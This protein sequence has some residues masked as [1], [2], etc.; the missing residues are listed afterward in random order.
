LR[1]TCK[2]PFQFQQFAVQGIVL[3]AVIVENF[4][5][6]QPEPSLS[7]EKDSDGNRNGENQAYT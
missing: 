3:A 5:E 2:L 7:P 4:V 1:Q 6:P